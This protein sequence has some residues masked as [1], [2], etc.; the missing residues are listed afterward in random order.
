MSDVPQINVNV[1]DGLPEAPQD[2]VIYGRRNAAWVDMT[3]PA[4]LQ[5]NR[6]NAAEVAAYTPLDGEPVWDSESKLLY[7]G[8]GQTQGGIAVGRPEVSAYQ[9]TA[10][11]IPDTQYTNA[12]PITLFPSGSAWQVD[13]FAVIGGDFNDNSDYEY[14]VGG[15]SGVDLYGTLTYIDKDSTFVEHQLLNSIELIPIGAGQPALVRISAIAVLTSAPAT[16][17][18]GLR[19]EQTSFEAQA[20]EGLQRSAIVARRIA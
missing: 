4:N 19:P 15:F 11:A 3:A 5:V 6:G 1:V 12:T 2:S 20:G 14:K 8:D 7:V 18:F 17:S 13:Y 10:T 16:I 9:S